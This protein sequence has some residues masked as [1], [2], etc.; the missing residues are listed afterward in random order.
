MFASE[1]ESRAVKFHSCSMCR[2]M[3]FP[4]DRYVRV[5][6][7]RDG[8]FSHWKYCRTCKRMLDAYTRE[9]GDR[10]CDHDVVSDYLRTKCY[11]CYMAYRECQE[12]PER[13]EYVRK[14]FAEEKGYT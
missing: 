8:R 6:E 4:G 2:R 13:C 5:T 10:L 14:Q 9:T 1:K 7:F 11:G 3:I 12:R